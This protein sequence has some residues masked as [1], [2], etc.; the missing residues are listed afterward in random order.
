MKRWERALVVPNTTLSE[1]IEVLDRE[2]LRIALIVDDQRRLLGTLTDGDVRRALLDKQTLEVSVE[3]IMFRQPKVAYRGWSKARML[4]WMEQHDLLQLPIVDDNHR[5]IGLETLHGLLQKPRQDNPVFLMAGG[6]G[7][8]LRPLTNT[9]PKPMLRVGNKPILELI[10]EGFVNAG[11]YRFY[12]S[13]HYMSAQIRDYFGDG[14]QWNV[15]IQYIHEETPLGTGGALGLLPHDEINKPLFMM[16]GDLLTNLNYLSLLAFHEE[17]GGSATMCV[18]E[19]EYQVPYGVIEV[20]GHRAKTIVEKPV[21]TF[22]INAGI[23][24]LSPELVKSVAPREQIDMPSLLEKEMSGDRGVNFYPLE[25]YW[26]D[27]GQMDDFQRAQ[28]DIG[29]MFHGQ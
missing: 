26:L 10:L 14:S 7:K 4:A 21:H 23:Y 12:I 11:F 29:E 28:L 3:S 22:N 8:R 5:L 1:A 20:D 15:S 19:F 25:G 16:N 24:L 9:C 18:R 17:H 2:A 27:I 6:F 13:T